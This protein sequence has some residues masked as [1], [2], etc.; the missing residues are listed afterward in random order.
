MREVDSKQLL[1]PSCPSSLP[2]LVSAPA[3]FPVYVFHINVTN[4]AGDKLRVINGLI[5]EYVLFMVI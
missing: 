3:I 1:L 4:A 2:I 5:A